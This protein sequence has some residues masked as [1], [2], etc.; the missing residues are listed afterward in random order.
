MAENIKLNKVDLYYNGSRVEVNAEETILIRD[1]R[2]YVE[3]VNDRTHTVKEGETWDLI[4][5]DKYGDSKYWHYIADINK[6]FN[7]FD[8]P[9]VGEGIIIPSIHNY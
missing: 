7:P 5:F 9:P 6:V 4:A 1:R 2:S 8:K 3:S